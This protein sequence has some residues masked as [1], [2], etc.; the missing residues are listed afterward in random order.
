MMFGQLDIHNQKMNVD[1]D[2][3]LFTTISDLDHPQCRTQTLQFLEDNVAENLDDLRF[4][5]A[6]LDIRPKT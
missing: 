4:G 2:L 1:T 6:F 3:T 5:F